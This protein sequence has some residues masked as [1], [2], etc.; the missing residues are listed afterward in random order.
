MQKGSQSNGEGTFQFC[1]QCTLGSKYKRAVGG[2]CVL[3]SYRS[4]AATTDEHRTP[5]RLKN[6]AHVNIHFTFIAL[7][8]IHF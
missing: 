8:S 5:S 7:F 2:L 3:L 6:N 1:M 4:T